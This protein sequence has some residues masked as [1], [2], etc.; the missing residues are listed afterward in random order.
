[1]TRR[2]PVLLFA[3]LASLPLGAVEDPAA[4]VERLGSLYS[5]EREEAFASLESA[6]NAAE[7][8]LRAGLRNADDRVRLS[9]ARLLARIPTDASAAALLEAAGDPEPDVA[10]AAREAVLRIAQT[11]DLPDVERTFRDE[12]RRLVGELKASGPGAISAAEAALREFGRLADPYLVQAL[13]DPAPGVRLGALRLLG[14]RKDPALAP[15]LLPIL[16]DADPAVREAARDTLS[17]LGPAALQ[18]VEGARERGELP[19]EE[20]DI[21]RGLLLREQVERILREQIADD[22]R[23]G[24]CVDQ[25]REIRAMGPGAVH[26]LLRI[27]KDA[28]YDFGDLPEPHVETMRRLAVCALGEF[29]H[30]DVV[31]LLKEQ[32]KDRARSTDDQ[33]DIAVALHQRGDPEPFRAIR[34][35]VEE[36]IRRWRGVPPMQREVHRLYVQLAILDYRVADYP[37]ARGS[38]ETVLRERKAAGLEN[39][40][41]PP[42]GLCWYNLAC[43]LS[44]EGRKKEALE[45]FGQAVRSRNVSPEWTRRDRDLDAIRS[46]PQF[47]ALLKESEKIQKVNRLR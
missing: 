2:L 40:L 26:V 18:A 11:K 7:A 8:A 46:D 30:P 42:Y 37:K 13:A 33:I 29:D 34:N 6:G 27:V 31:P 47:E 5:T 28:E 19:A 21:L 38:L 12:I 23:T 24:F 14:H 45:A 35:T 41:G 22:Q 3:A 39:D 25:F 1:M 44:L 43:L 10:D 15:S 16:K 9:C 36:A 17:R 32:L 4:L 20:A